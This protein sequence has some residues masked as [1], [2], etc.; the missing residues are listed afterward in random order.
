MLYYDEVWANCSQ[1]MHLTTLYEIKNNSLKTF[2]TYRVFK[3]NIICLQVEKCTLSG[4]TKQIRDCA[5]RSKGYPKMLNVFCDSG[6]DLKMK[7]DTFYRD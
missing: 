2:K 1:I 5:E 4:E 7:G 3:S 6:Y